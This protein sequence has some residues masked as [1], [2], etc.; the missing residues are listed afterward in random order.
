MAPYVALISGRVPWRSLTAHFS[1]GEPGE[2]DLLSHQRMTGS[3]QLDQARDPSVHPSSVGPVYSCPEV[4][5]VRT[6]CYLLVIIV[7]P[8]GNTRDHNPTTGRCERSYIAPIT[9][10]TA[11]TNKTGQ[12]PCHPLQPRSG[13]STAC[14]I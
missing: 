7:I 9:A 10:K 3:D 1:H 2:G 13:A 5:A 14:V 8:K 6:F 4:G 11:H 12:P